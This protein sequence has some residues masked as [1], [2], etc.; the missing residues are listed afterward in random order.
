M[1]FNPISTGT[2]GSASISGNL[3]QNDRDLLNQLVDGYRGSFTGSDL[4]DVVAKMSART[5]QKIPA[6]VP[7]YGDFF[8][9][10]FGGET[11]Y[12]RYDVN[13]GT[14]VRSA[15]YSDILALQAQI[16]SSTAKVDFQ[17]ASTVV[18]NLNQYPTRPM[19]EVWT[20]V[21][22]NEFALSD[23]KIRFTEETI[24]VTFGGEYVTGYL[25]LK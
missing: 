1:A 4:P 3:T 6:W 16:D 18:T 9:G 24:E 11:N 25:I 23:A 19:V 12:F 5:I 7:T 15:D 20:Q 14:W 8:I 17:N 21:A 10:V 2:G 13:I 22:P